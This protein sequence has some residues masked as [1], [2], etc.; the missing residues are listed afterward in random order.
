MTPT[1][2]CAGG[3]AAEMEGH[4]G[5]WGQDAKDMGE[6]A[7]EQWLGLR[8]LKLPSLWVPKLD[9]CIT[10]GKAGGNQHYHWQQ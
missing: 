1:P 5:S 3:A 6:A 7:G 9:I 8:G 4:G 2:S 10:P